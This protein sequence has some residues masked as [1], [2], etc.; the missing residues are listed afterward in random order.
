MIP[1]KRQEFIVFLR[2]V[3]G[4]L[5]YKSILPVDSRT[6]WDLPSAPN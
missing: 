2:E 6:G 1:Q 4:Y 5:E 3:L